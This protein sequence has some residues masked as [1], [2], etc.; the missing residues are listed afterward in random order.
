MGVDSFPK[1]ANEQLHVF[2]HRFPRSDSTDYC[3]DTNQLQAPFH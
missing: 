1:W 2:D 3:I